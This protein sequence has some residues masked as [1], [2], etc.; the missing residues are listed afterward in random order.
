MK[1]PLARLLATLQVARLRTK[2]DGKAEPIKSQKAKSVLGNR[3][4]QIGF[5]DDEFKLNSKQPSAL[6]KTDLHM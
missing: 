3:I 5:S 1:K 6:E 2:R 4:S